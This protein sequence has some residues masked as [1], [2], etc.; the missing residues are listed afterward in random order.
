MS[1]QLTINGQT[2]EAPSGSASI[3]QL[4]E[5]IGVHV[6][7]SCRTNGKCKEC[8]VEVTEG[9]AMLSSPTAAESHL[10]GNFRLAC[11]TCITAASG[12]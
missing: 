2:T 10:R 12:S 1:A 6:P 5:F 11:Q 8:V 3:F 7:T 9:L 4:A